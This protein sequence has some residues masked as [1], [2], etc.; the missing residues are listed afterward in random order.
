MIN[1]VTTYQLGYVEEGSNC[2]TDTKICLE[3]PFQSAK[4]QVQVQGKTVQYIVGDATPTEGCV[5][6]HVAIIYM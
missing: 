5:H 2:T 6:P 1:R 4:V 3:S